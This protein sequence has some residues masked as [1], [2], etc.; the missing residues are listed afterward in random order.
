MPSHKP[1]TET[2]STRVDAR[3]KVQLPHKEYKS[4]ADDRLDSIVACLP[5]ARRTKARTAFVGW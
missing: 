3:D 2:P 4:R 1:A 5:T